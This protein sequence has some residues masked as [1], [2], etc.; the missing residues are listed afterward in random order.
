MLG[1]QLNPASTMAQKMS[2]TL[3]AELEA[4]SSAFTAAD[5]SNSTLVGPQ[6]HSRVI[7]SVCNSFKLMRCVRKEL[8]SL[9]QRICLLHT[10]YL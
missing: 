4:H 5:S 1:N 8:V 2:D 7:A 10:E 3:S 6:L 9:E